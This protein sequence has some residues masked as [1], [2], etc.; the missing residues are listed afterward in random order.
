MG[1]KPK[2]ALGVKSLKKRRE[3]WVKAKKI[4]PFLRGCEFK[5]RNIG[6]QMETD[7]GEQKKG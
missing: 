2:P 1:E 3:R 7:E 4:E 5:S 6:Q